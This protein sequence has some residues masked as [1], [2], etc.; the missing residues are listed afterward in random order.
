MIWLFTQ[1]CNLEVTSLDSCKNK[2]AQ[3]KT[4]GIISKKI[5]DFTPAKNN[6]E[7]LSPEE[8]QSPA[9]ET[10]TRNLQLNQSPYCSLHYFYTN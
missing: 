7:L 6:N 4:S 5:V 10:C 1:K 2:Y 9:G 8:N 3:M